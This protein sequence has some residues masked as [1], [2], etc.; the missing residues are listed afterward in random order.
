MDED[1]AWYGSRPRP[2]PHSTRRRPSSRDR[3]QQP[4]LFSA[5]VYCGH[6]RPSQLL[7]SSYFNNSI[8][9]D[10]PTN[11]TMHFNDAPLNYTLAEVR[12]DR[13]RA[14][15]ET[16]LYGGKDCSFKYICWS[17]Y[18]VLSEVRQWEKCFKHW[19]HRPSLNDQ[20]HGDED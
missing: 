19:K 1:A 18:A 10:D 11:V 13:P 8:D 16:L 15:R 9:Q 6:S 17:V 2:R 7:L 14:G 3:A 12:G 4:P 5:H 20:K